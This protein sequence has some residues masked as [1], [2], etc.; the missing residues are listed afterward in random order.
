MNPNLVGLAL[1]EAQRLEPPRSLPWIT[2]LSA[3]P[4]LSGGM[5][6]NSVALPAETSLIIKRLPLGS[7]GK[8]IHRAL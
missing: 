3:C 8:P 1:E 2:S 6:N 5:K 4:V 7:Y